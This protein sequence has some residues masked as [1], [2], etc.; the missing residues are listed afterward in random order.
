MKKT[1][2][3][4]KIVAVCAAVSL[5]SGGFLHAQS[6]VRFNLVD[7]QPIHSQADMD[8]LATG[9]KVAMVCGMC[10][11]VSLTTYS[12]DATS[13]GHVKWMQSGFTRTCPMCGGKVTT[14]V[15]KDGNTKFTC[16]KCGSD[17]GF[18]SSLKMAQK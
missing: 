10:K 5:L 15:D 12:S 17:S 7:G 18:V 8:A 1:Y 11:S 3:I 6:G 9:D 16:S 4:L 2:V 13:K 14:E